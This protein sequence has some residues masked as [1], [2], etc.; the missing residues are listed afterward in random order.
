MIAVLC[1]YVDLRVIGLWCDQH[2]LD[3]IREHSKAS[4]TSRGD[5]HCWYTDKQWIVCN[6]N[7]IFVMI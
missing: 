3:E 5:G 7:I 2:D 4:N 6:T 1:C